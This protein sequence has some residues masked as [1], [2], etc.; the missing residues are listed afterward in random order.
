M[1]LLGHHISGKQK[2]VTAQVDSRTI[3]TDATALRSFGKTLF[4]PLNRLS[5]PEISKSLHDT[6]NPPEDKKVYHNQG[7][8]PYR[9]IV[10]EENDLQKQ[11][12]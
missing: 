4:Y 1:S 8:S 3:I 5:F 11:R 9:A 10:L 12:R 7:V 2:I 6:D